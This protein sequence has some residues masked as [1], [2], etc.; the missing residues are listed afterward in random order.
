MVVDASGAGPEPRAISSRIILSARAMR[1]AMW[2]SGVEVGAG[3]V[4]KMVLDQ[5]GKFS[6]FFANLKDLRIQV[7]CACG[8]GLS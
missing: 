6:K 4:V 2:V 5:L 8:W 7:G 1:S 3:G